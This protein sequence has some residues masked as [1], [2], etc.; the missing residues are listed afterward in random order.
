MLA[1]IRPLMLASV[2]LTILVMHVPAQGIKGRPI[3]FTEPADSGS[4]NSLKPNQSRLSL[5]ESGP[6]R[7]FQNQ[8]PG[9]SLDGMILTTPLPPPA[10][11]IRESRGRD[12][13]NRRRDWMFRSPEELMSV[14]SIEEKYKNPD[15]T[16]DGRDRN[17]LRPM[18]RAYYDAISSNRQTGTTNRL[19]QI[20]GGISG[21]ASSSSFTGMIPGSSIGP[22]PFESMESAWPRSIQTGPGSTGMR[23]TDATDYFGYNQNSAFPNKPSEAQIRRAED[24]MEIHNFSGTPIAHPTP[25]ATHIYSSPYVNSGFFDSH[26]TQL[27]AAAANLKN[28]LNGTA[29]GGIGAAGMAPNYTSPASEPVH[30]TPSSSPFININ[31]G[32]F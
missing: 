28:G 9:R 1:T 32:G 21:P 26:S 8:T 31:R 13:N 30:S 24:F 4:G 16:P 7:S 17:S 20:S 5:L 10:P 6:E 29:M 23:T 11:V 3:E 19:Q 15:L 18:E 22:N 2:V 27:P 12:D 25:G 14:D